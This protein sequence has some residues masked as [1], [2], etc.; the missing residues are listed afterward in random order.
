M[1]ELKPVYFALDFS[2]GS[3]ALAFIQSHDLEGVPVKVGM[4][5]FYKEG[6]PFIAELKRQ[7]HD[8]FLDLKLYDIPETVRR[9]MR[10]LAALGVDIV[11]VHA[12]GG[13]RMIEAARQGLK[14][15]AFDEQPLL[16][17]VTVLTSMDEWT[18]RRE[19]NVEA[20]PK[21]MVIHYSRLAKAHGADGVVCSVHEAAMVKKET[22]LFTLTPGIRLPGGDTHDQ[23]RTSTP[24][25]AGIQASDAIVAGRPIRDSSAP[26]DTYQTIKGDFLYGKQTADS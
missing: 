23:K 15:G 4:E 24:E 16:F 11:N 9:S 10:N 13:S 8:I 17:A 20:S 22:G 25:E 5:L 6:A 19:L 2:S 26:A 14:E 18:V 1:K 21:E 3:E 7:N 12:S